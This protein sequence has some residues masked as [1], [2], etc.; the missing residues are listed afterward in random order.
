MGV[1]ENC[2]PQKF[3]PV[4]LSLLPVPAPSLMNKGSYKPK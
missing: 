4:R 1:Q 2:Q 3:L